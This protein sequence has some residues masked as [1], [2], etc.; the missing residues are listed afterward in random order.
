MELTSTLPLDSVSVDLPKP[1]SQKKCVSWKSCM[2]SMTVDMHT[3]C[4]LCRDFECNIDSLCNECSVCSEDL[5]FA[6]IKQIE[7]DG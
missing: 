2:S 1:T 4:I 3:V 7:F 6:Y 5:M